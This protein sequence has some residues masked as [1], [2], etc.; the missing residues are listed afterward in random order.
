MGFEDLAELA[1]VVEDLLDALRQGRLTAR[2]ALVDAL[3]T[4]STTCAPS[5]RPASRAARR[6]SCPRRR[7][8]GC[9]P[10]W[11]SR[12]PHRRRRSPHRTPS[13]RLRSRPPSRRHVGPGRPSRRPR[14]RPTSRCPPPAPCRSR[15]RRSG[16]ARG[17]SSPSSGSTRWSAWSARR[18]P[19][20][21]AW[22]PCSPQH[23]L[24]P[25]GPDRA[26][27]RHPLARRAAAADDARPHGP[28]VDRRRAAAPGRARPRARLR[29]AGRVGG[30]RR[31]HRARPQ[32][33]RPARARP[34]CTWSATPSTTASR[35]PRSGGPRASRRPARSGCTPCSS[36]ARSC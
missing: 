3:L 22:P 35:R 11:A 7:R 16:R 14:T 25:S 29:Q 20:S 21:C 2:P 24:D 15:S 34:C 36:A 28:G 30:A 26:P 8:A 17:S 31:G 4:A 19:R 10:P 12:P 5:P 27:R 33:A 23:G 6:R 18:P 13:R 9:A 32:P 1:H